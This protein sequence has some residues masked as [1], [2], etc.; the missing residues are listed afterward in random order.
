[1]LLLY[2]IEIEEDKDCD[3]TPCEIYLS[4]QDHPIWIECSNCGAWFFTCCCKPLSVIMDA[5]LSCWKASLHPALSVTS[6]QRIIT[7]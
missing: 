6:Q 7:K 5:L 3:A 1:M 2:S 4:G